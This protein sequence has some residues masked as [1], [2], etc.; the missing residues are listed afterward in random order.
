[1]IF[2]HCLNRIPELC[3]CLC[4]SAACA[5]TEALCFRLVSPSF[6]PVPSV[7]L[8]KHT[9]RILMKFARDNN[10]DQQIEWLHF[11]W[12]WN[13]DKTAGYDRILESMLVGV[14]AELN[15]CSCLAIEFT[16]FRVTHVALPV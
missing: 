12:S 8:H 5:A 3:T 11:G 7:F 9:E 16:N 1:M 10:Y 4:A 6:C 14:D 13:S 15:R 2:V